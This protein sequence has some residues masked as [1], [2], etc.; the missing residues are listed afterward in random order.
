MKNET[1]SQ[2]RLMDWFVRKSNLRIEDASYTLPFFLILVLVVVGMMVWGLLTSPQLKQP[3]YWIPFVAI[4]LVHLIL[5]LSNLFIEYKPGAFAIYLG[6][7]GGLVFAATYLSGIPFLATGLYLALIGESA[8]TLRQFTWTVLTAGVYLFL[9]GINFRLL[10]PDENFY[11]WAIT[12]IPMT[13]FVVIYVRLFLNQANARTEAQHLAARLEEANRQLAESAAQIESLTLTAERQRMARELHDTLSAGLAG[14]ILQ[15]EAADSH[16]TIGKAER[17]QAI[18]QQAMERARASLADARRVIDSLRAGE[19]SRFDLKD[20]LYAEVRKFETLSGLPCTVS[21]SLPDSLDRAVGEALLRIVSESL[22]NIFQHANARNVWVS[23]H[24]S[25]AVLQMEVRDDGRG[26]D[27]QAE[28]SVNG[29]YGLIGMRE[30]A[31]L[32]GA[33]LE[34]ESISGRGTAVRVR[35]PLHQTDAARET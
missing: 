14:T 5:H 11:Y 27:T 31:G 1:S 35:L 19:E 10:A 8:G 33:H 34:I 24:V 21:F 6:I 17:A 9:S 18:V 12:T 20:S 3:S 16:L 32:A 7:Q 29:H 4:L 30:R 28:Q 26:F 2:N 25:D 13:L 15:L 23:S 22:H